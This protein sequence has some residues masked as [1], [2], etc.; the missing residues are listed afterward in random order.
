[1]KV[2]LITSFYIYVALLIAPVRAVASLITS[3][4]TDL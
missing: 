1:M 2:K 4:G 3:Y